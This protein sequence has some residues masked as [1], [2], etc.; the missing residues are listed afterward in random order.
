[1]MFLEGSQIES[2]NESFV[3]SGYV[4]WQNTSAK[5]VASRLWLIFQTLDRYALKNVEPNPSLGRAQS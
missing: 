3:R 5:S 1:M 4:P 2:L